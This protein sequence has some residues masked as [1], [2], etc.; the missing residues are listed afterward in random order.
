M[1]IAFGSFEKGRAY[2]Q[3]WLSRERAAKRKLPPGKPMA[4]RMT[5]T[6]RIERLERKAAT[7]RAF[8]VA[9]DKCNASGTE[10]NWRRVCEL[11]ARVKLDLPLTRGK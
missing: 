10:A 5:A 7:L 8:Y 2:P 6:A 3:D 4:A 1:G 9:R 11:L